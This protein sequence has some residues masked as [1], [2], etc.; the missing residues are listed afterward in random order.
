M[1]LCVSIL[2]AV[3]APRST[4]N[5]EGRGMTVGDE[6]RRGGKREREEDREEK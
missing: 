1:S 3:V 2:P 6:G 5:E 4:L